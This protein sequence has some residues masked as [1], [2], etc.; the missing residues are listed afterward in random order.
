MRAASG[1]AVNDDEPRILRR[2]PPDVRET[3][4]VGRY[5]AWLER[6][7]ALRFDDYDELQRWSVAN[8]DAFWS[9]VWDFFEVRAHAQPTAVLASDA[10]PGATWFP[11]A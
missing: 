10:M 9:S 4:E 5:L 7:R 1:L 2:P 11:G 6:E 8:L 3:T